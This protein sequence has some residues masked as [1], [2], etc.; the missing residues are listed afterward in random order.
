MRFIKA[1][2]YSFVIACVLVM[3]LTL[4]WMFYAKN[5]VVTVQEPIIAIRMAEI[6]IGISLLTMSAV[7]VWQDVLKHRHRIEIDF[8]KESGMFWVTDPNIK[9][10]SS[11]PMGNVILDMD[12]QGRLKGF[13]ILNAGK[14]NIDM[15]EHDKVT[16]ELE[17]A[18]KEKGFR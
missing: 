7:F 17:E 18:E 1:Y 6:F 13:E 9:Y 11:I 3:T 5:G 16:K 12:K 10:W 15:E 2:Y 4:V 14:L 8:D